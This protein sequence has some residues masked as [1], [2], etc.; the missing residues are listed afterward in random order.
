MPKPAEQKK[1]FFSHFR[2][3]FIVSVVVFLTCLGITQWF[4]TQMSYKDIDY[5]LRLFREDWNRRIDRNAASLKNTFDL[6]YNS[7]RTIA[8]LPGVQRIDQQATNLEGDTIV[9]VQQIYHNLFS[10]FSASKIYIVSADLDPQNPLAPQKPIIAFDDFLNQKIKE[11]SEEDLGVQEY[12]EMKKQIAYFKSYFPLLTHFTAFNYPALFSPEIL[13]S[14]ISPLLDSSLNSS[15]EKTSPDDIRKGFV[16][17]LPFYS[18]EGQLKGLISVIFRSSVFAQLLDEPFFVLSAGENQSI[19]NSHPP[20]SLLKELIPI[21]G[22]LDT[23][24]YS[25]FKAI[26]VPLKD[27]KKWKLFAAV[28]ESTWKESPIYKSIRL[29]TRWIWIIGIILSFSLSILSWVLMYSRTRALNLLNQMR[30][31]LENAQRQLFQTQKSDLVTKVTREMA[32]DFQNNVTPIL[33][34]TN[35]LISKLAPNSPEVRQAEVIRK[36]AEKAGQVIQQLMLLSKVPVSA[37]LKMSLLPL[38]KKVHETLKQTLPEKVEVTLEAD[39]ELW[40]IAGDTSQLETVFMNLGF[41][42]RDAMPEGGTLKLSAHN[43][44]EDKSENQHTPSLPVGY[45]VKI[46][47]S[48]TG[49]G[50]SEEMLNKIFDPS[51]KRGKKSDNA[52]D[53]K[54]YTLHSIITDHKGMILVDSEIGKGTQFTIY[55]PALTALAPPTDK[56]KVSP[57]PIETAVPPEPL[58]ASTP[59]TSPAPQADSPE[60]PPPE[61]SSEPAITEHTPE[62]APEPTPEPI[63]D[64]AVTST[65]APETQN[66]TASP[67]LTTEASDH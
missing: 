65:P 4:I 26:A 41:N 8:M 21:L 62:S 37:K 48:D 53:I 44:T 23:E 1:N 20:R 31:S 52:D 6:V 40:E 39:P 5:G 25:F 57:K 60:S 13:T 58:L 16:Y 19:L 42:A 45:Y 7:T 35:L 30:A 28:P 27:E 66:T 22:E 11:P 46:Q 67:N 43:I 61:N 64:P 32:N 15:G 63:P 55:L 14:D 10:S 50:M 54:L 18:P 36:S 49:Q 2:N 33:A 47:V 29:N 59:E 51:F 12:E 3:V 24:T 38:L 17:S 56:S 9:T 34:Y